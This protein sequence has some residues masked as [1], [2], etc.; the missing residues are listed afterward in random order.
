MAQPNVRAAVEVRV[1]TNEYIRRR[2]IAAGAS[3]P[4]AYTSAA[5][6]AVETEV[7]EFLAAL[8][9]LTH[10][11]HVLE[12]G[13][14]L[15]DT[16]VALAD[17]CR[18]NGHGLVTSVEID[19]ARVTSARARLDRAGLTP[20]ARVLHG[21]YDAVNLTP[22]GGYMYGVALFDSWWER[23]REYRAAEPHL[24]PGALLVF[25]DC[26]EQHK[27]GAVRE[28]VESLERAGLIKGFYIPTPHGIIV[29]QQ[30]A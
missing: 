9:R 21:S 8:V 19:E 1:T 18:R 12:T 30:R 2:P 10:P 28:R 15:A 3:H 25:H 24:K 17:A 5:P 4:D 20:H 16:T 13:T 22:P 11:D 6:Q 7:A 23:D 14:Y 27:D 26:G 29:A